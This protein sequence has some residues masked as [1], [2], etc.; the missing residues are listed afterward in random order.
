MARKQDEMEEKILKEQYDIRKKSSRI[1]KHSLAS[2]KYEME[3]IN[4]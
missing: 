2:E 4:L 3:D 1:S